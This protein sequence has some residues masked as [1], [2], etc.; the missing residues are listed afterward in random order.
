MDKVDIF[1]QFRANPAKPRQVVIDYAREDLID[2]IE[3]ASR[4]KHRS[5]TSRFLAQIKS[6]WKL[7][8]A[9]AMAGAV[10]ITAGTLAAGVFN[11]DSSPKGLAILEKAK[12]AIASGEDGSIRHIVEIGADALEEKVTDQRMETWISPDG[13]LRHTKWSVNGKVIL[14]DEAN[15]TGISAYE[16]DKD[17][18]QKYEYGPQYGEDVRRNA[19]KGDQDGLYKLTTSGELG[20]VVSEEKVDYEGKPAIKVVVESKDGSRFT[21]TVDAESYLPLEQTS[22]LPD[23]DISAPHTK[24]YEYEYLPD[25]TENRQLLKMDEHPGAKVENVDTEDAKKTGQY[26]YGIATD[27]LSL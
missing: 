21:L 26:F 4:P 19:V 16:G 11:G 20:K 23:D 18:I 6:G 15:E 1:K 25:T 22:D 27:A 9:T 2:L 24:K 17:L 10:L 7:R 13:V 14:E 3:S 12:A 8:I 5:V